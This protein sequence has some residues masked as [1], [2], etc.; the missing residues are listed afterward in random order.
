MTL[1]VTL[2]P[3]SFETRVRATGVVDVA[4]ESGYA[5]VRAPGS[6]KLLSAKPKGIVK[7]PAP[8]GPPSP[9]ITLRA[10]ARIATDGRDNGIWFRKATPLP[11]GTKARPARPRWS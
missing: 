5:V 4:Q 2:R 3:R 11:T 9:L 6:T 8:S 10:G 7:E 1:T